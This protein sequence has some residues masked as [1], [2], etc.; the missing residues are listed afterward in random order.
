[1]TLAAAPETFEAALSIDT[2]GY[3]ALFGGLFADNL[4]VESAVWFGAALA[5]ASLPV[6]LGTRRK[7]APAASDGATRMPVG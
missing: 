2:L 1:M 7:T 3:R 6:T 4:G 5:M